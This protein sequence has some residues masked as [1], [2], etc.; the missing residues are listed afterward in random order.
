MEFLN[1]FIQ[2]YNQKRE[3]ITETKYINY[4]TSLMHNLNLIHPEM[5]REFS[6]NIALHFK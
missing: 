2:L 4:S 1:F 6:I 3:Q 5:S